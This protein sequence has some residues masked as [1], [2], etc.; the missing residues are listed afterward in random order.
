MAQWR[1]KMQIFQYTASVIFFAIFI[2]AV[3]ARVALLRRKGIRAVV[4]GATDKT[5]FLLVPFVAAIIY[6]VL[7][8]RFPL[9][10]W[11]P[12]VHPFWK[13]V[14]PDGRAWPSLRQPSQA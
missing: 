14:I 7:A 1:M 2:L 9:P 12:L 5:D 10:L 13:T 11:E 4:F 6:A 3:L 8:N